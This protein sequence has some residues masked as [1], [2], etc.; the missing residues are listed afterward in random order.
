[1][2][3]ISTTVVT[4]NPRQAVIDAV[5]AK[6]AEAWKQRYE[7]FVLDYA[8]NATEMFTAEEVRLAYLS[9]P[10]LP[11]A[12]R[13]QSSGGIYQRLRREGV[14]IVSGQKRSK[15]FGNKLDA[16]RYAR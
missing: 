11:H 9:T 12:A 10:N 8:K 7:Q 16:Y 4:D 5:L 1:M 3:D 13:E 15:K 2:F 14:L 6:E